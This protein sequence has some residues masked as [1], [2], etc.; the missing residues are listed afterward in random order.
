[1]IITSPAPGLAP[2]TAP[3]GPGFLISGLQEL[4]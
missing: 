2:C 4:R 1:M 3:G